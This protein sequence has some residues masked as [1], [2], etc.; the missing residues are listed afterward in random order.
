MNDFKVVELINRDWDFIVID[1]L[2]WSFG[3]ALA[4]FKHRQW[5]LNGKLGNESKIVI[6]S[7]SAMTSMSAESIR[8]VGEKIII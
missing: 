6:Y 3:F 7:T 4:T 8:S 2:F 1:H 5:E